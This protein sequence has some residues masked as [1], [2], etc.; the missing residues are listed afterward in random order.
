MLPEERVNPSV[1][2]I[3]S[4]FGLLVFLAWL[5]IIRSGVP[6]GLSGAAGREPEAPALNL[7]PGEAEPLSPKRFLDFIFLTD[8]S[9]PGTANDDSERESG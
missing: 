6:P 4:F 5:L 7:L 3:F 8:P 2:G 1:S 9:C